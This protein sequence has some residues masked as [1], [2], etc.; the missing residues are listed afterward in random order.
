MDIWSILAYVLGIVFS[1]GIVA[2]IRNAARQK[3]EDFFFNRGRGSVVALFA[4]CFI[5]QLVMGHFAAFDS[6][7]ALVDLIRKT[8]EMVV[9][10]MGGHIA[11]G[12]AADSVRKTFP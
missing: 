2:G 12:A 8:S 5:Y 9:A 11:L 4:L 7:Q 6:A 10:A 3:G 1:I